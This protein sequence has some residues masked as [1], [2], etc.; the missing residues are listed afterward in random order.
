MIKYMP[1]LIIDTED[2]AGGLVVAADVQTSA[3]LLILS[4]F[5]HAIHEWALLVN[6]VT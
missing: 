2:N 5:Q 4:I 6:V 3:L 1:N